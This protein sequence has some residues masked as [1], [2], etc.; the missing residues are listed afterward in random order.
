MKKKMRLGKL[1]DFKLFVKFRN[2]LFVFSKYQ[3]S[4]YI[5]YVLFLFTI[6]IYVNRAFLAFSDTSMIFSQFGVL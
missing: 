1:E 4:A 6:I 3:V 2:K 5:T